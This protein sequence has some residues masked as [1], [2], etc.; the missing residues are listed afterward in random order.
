MLE[1]RIMSLHVETCIQSGSNEF[2]ATLDI[3]PGS[4]REQVFRTGDASATKLT[5]VCSGENI[6]TVSETYMRDG[7]IDPSEKTETHTLTPGDKPHETQIN[8]K[9]GIGNKRPAAVAS[10]LFTA[11]K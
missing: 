10:Y 9:Q 11:T 6:S 7:K 8:M 3:L 2:R 4:K 1:C 5:I